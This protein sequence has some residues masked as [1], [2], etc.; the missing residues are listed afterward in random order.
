ML[1]SLVAFAAA[2]QFAVAFTRSYSLSQASIPSLSSSIRRSYSTK[3]EN[4]GKRVQRPIHAY[5]GSNLADLVKEKR[6]PKSKQA[7]GRAN[8]IA[9]KM[10]H[11]VE[12]MINSRS[13]PGSV[14]FQFDASQ[15][16]D[17][18]KQYKIDLSV[19]SSVTGTLLLRAAITAGRRDVCRVLLKHGALPLAVDSEGEIK[20]RLQY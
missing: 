7:N 3:W 17:K 9:Q 15:I 19:S 2:T 6:S 20:R 1:L 11:L 4:D 10:I 16:D 5:S 8:N 12:K 18:I 13:I 14:E